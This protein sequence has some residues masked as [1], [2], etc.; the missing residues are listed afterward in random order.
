M[1]LLDK[2]EKGELQN[3]GESLTAVGD[4]IRTVGEMQ[5]GGA[6]AMRFLTAIV[7]SL[8]SAV[9]ALDGKFDSFARLGTTSTPL[10]SRGGPS[11]AKSGGG[12]APTTPTKKKKCGLLCVR[13]NA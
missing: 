5:T 8:Q 4:Q 3:I 10:G 9:S 12:M 13:H 11:A 1:V 2:A 6:E 7:Q